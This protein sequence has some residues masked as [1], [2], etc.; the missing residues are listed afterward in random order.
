MADQEHLNGLEEGATIL[1]TLG[2][3]VE[4][5]G[6]EVLAATDVRTGCTTSR[7]VRMVD[8]EGMGRYGALFR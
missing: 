2:C 3:L 1:N 4:V 5:L 6:S 8:R 7:G